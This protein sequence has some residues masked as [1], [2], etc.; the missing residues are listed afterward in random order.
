MVLC[1]EQVPVKIFETVF[2][3]D[4][5]SVIL[6]FN[7]KSDGK[8]HYLI[9]QTAK[10]TI[11]PNLNYLRSKYL[12]SKMITQTEN[13]SEYDRLR[14][15]ASTM[16]PIDES[17]FKE[18][19]LPLHE[20]VFVNNDETIIFYP[21]GMCGESYPSLDGYQLNSLSDSTYGL[22]VDYFI[23]KYNLHAVFDPDECDRLRTKANT[24]PPVA[25]SEYVSN[26][27]PS[28]TKWSETYYGRP[29]SNESDD[30]D[31]DDDC[32]DYDSGEE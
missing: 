25:D 27:D 32:F 20:I 7:A 29:N 26:S 10:T 17:M 28:A 16:G 19:V 18:P 31:S 11:K 24:L 23:D 13:K 1:F 8:Y 22:D 30:D 12:V 21:N 6:Y 14:L 15:K 3:D 5:E 9:N 2:T 4:T